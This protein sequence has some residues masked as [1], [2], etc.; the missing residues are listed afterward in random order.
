M[1]QQILSF[2]RIFPDKCLQEGSSSNAGFADYHAVL[3]LGGG[4]DAPPQLAQHFLTP[5][6]VLT[7]DR[8]QRI[9]IK[10]FTH[11]S[12]FSLICL[13]NVL[14]ISLSILRLLLIQRR[15]KSTMI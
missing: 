2:W 8:A 12:A 13:V 5:H 3:R 15:K 6:K 4:H 10:K 9:R 11:P 1:N 14:I 7:N